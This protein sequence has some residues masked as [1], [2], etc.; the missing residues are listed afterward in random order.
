MGLGFRALMFGDVGLVL[1]VLFRV[2]VINI[3]IFNR[4]V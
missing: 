4:C 2:I 1:N 3:F